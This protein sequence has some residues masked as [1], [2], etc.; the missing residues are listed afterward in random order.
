MATKLTLEKE[1]QTY[2]QKLP[3]LLANEGKFVVICGENVDGIF[4]SYSDAL[5]TGYEKFGIRP[6]LVKKISATEQ[7]SYFTRDIGAPCH[8]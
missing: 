1:I 3:E 5:K 2:N 8:I 4:E 6:F 7:I